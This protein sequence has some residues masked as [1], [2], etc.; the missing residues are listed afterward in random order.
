MDSWVFYLEL[1]SITIIVYFKA[2]V[3]SDFASGGPFKLTAVKDNSEK[4]VSRSLSPGGV[5]MCSLGKASS[6]S[7]VLWNLGS[8]QRGPSVY[9]S[10]NL[11]FPSHLN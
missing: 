10:Q 8:A 2:Q 11:P 4:C 3:V 6:D 7:D 5:F 1:K 9:T